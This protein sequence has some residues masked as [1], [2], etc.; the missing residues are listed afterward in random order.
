[1]LLTTER[2]VILAA[3]PDDLTRVRALGVTGPRP[4][5]LV[6]P[7]DGTRVQVT[8]RAGVTLLVAETR[9]GFCGHE[10]MVIL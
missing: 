7:F 10:S 8:A 4:V 9:C 5:R 1:M 3:M 2:D 6:C